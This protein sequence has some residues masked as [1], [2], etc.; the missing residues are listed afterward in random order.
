MTKMNHS[1]KTS[2]VTCKGTTL[3]NGLVHNVTNNVWEN[4]LWVIAVKLP[5]TRL[6][7]WTT[8]I[9]GCYARRQ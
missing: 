9:G 3:R 7:F 5:L 6:A 2:G 4:P 1:M 8:S